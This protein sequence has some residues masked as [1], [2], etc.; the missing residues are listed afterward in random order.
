M[1]KFCEEW[2]DNED[3]NYDYIFVKTTDEFFEYLNL[4]LKRYNEFI[5]KSPPNGNILEIACDCIIEKIFIEDKNKYTD[6]ISEL[7][8]NIK[9][10]LMSYGKLIDDMSSEYKIR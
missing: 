8:H 3:M 1:D 10:H 6:L 2:V 4:G 5:M 7:R 9:F